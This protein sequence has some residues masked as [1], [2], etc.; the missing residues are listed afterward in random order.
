MGDLSVGAI[1]G[2]VMMLKS[3]LPVNEPERECLPFQQ[4][5]VIEACANETGEYKDLCMKNAV[6]V[7]C[8][9]TKR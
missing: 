6:K 8:P 5:Q 7:F 3:F 1:I 2:G 4:Q 9:V